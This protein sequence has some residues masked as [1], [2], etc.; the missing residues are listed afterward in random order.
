MNEKIRVVDYIANRISELGIEHIFMLTGGGAMFLNDCVAKHDKLKAVCNHHEQASAMAAVAYAKY[1]NN[2][3]VTMPTTG[4]GS[5]NCITGLL[6]AWQDN[7]PCIFISGQVNKMQTCYNS[8]AQIRQFGVQEANIIEIVESITKYAVMIN[9]PEEI[10]YHFDKAI[11]HAD[12]G[13]KGPVWIDIPLDVQGALIEPHKL[14]RFVVEEKKVVCE[15]TQFEKFL[16]SSQRPVILAGNGVRL[17]NGVEA[18]QKFAEKHNIPVVTTF[19]GVDL[20]P[21]EH[22]LNIGRVGIKGNRAANFVMQNSDLLLSIGTR[23][24]VPTT[25]YKY[26]YFAREAKIV[27]VDI[28][29]EEHNKNTVKIDLFLQMDAKDFMN[30]SEFEYRSSDWWFNTCLK[31]KN[32]WPVFLPEHEDDSNGISLYYFMKKLSDSIGPESVVVGDAGSAYYVPSQALQIKDQQRHITSGAQAEMGFTIPACIGIAFAMKEPKVIGITGDG[33]FQT[34]IQ[35]LQTI[36]HYDLPVKLFIWNNDGYLSIRT[37]Q[38]K[39]FEG[40]FIGTD[41]ND[42]V[43]FPDV[44][45]IANAYGIKY[46]LF[47]NNE[48]LDAN[49]HKVIDFD[50]PVICEVMC[51]KWDQ[52]LPTLS[53]KKLD[54]GR[55]ISKPLEDMYPFLTREEFYD[56]MIIKAIEE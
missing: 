54:D 40:R 25:G 13:R 52:V 42:G 1:T 19:L 34:N 29:P 39:Y 37:T 9:E 35:E 20:L 47:S 26:E 33:S 53:A 45:K 7:V 50:G 11:Y 49:L 10:G 28:D 16:K 2:F 30:K 5:T 14:K 17:A 21:S 44:E 8:K 22:N 12:E 32:K 36:V 38:K 55:M 31:W 27:V 15:L 23:L 6:D 51:K 56:N 48:E 24:S 46:F 3:S 43:S 41:K 4:C 18:L